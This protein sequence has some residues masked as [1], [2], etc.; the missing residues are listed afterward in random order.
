LVVVVNKKYISSKVT[1]SCEIEPEVLF[2][3]QTKTVEA[4]DCTTFL[5][6]GLARGVPDKDNISCKIKDIK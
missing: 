5:I 2:G 3:E 1:V 6:W 4:R